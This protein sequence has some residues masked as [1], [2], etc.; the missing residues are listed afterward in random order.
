MLCSNF[1]LANYNWILSGTSCHWVWSK[2]DEFT[3]AQIQNGGNEQEGEKGRV[4]DDFKTRNIDSRGCTSG[5]HISLPNL[6]R[7]L[8]LVRTLSRYCQRVNLP[9]LALSLL[10]FRNLSVPNEHACRHACAFD[11]HNATE[12]FDSV[13]QRLVVWCRR[14]VVVFNVHVCIFMLG[15]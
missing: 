10:H 9:T 8:P 12:R 4:S 3:T 7:V 2:R 1:S 6:W 15:F 13:C 11:S 14:W 5:K